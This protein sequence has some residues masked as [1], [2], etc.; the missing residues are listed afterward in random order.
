MEN[1]IDMYTSSREKYVKA[2]TSTI[3]EE[4]GMV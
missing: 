1:D 4:L 2:Q 3:N